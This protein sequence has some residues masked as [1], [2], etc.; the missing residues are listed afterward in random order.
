[1]SDDDATHGLVLAFDTDDPQFVRGV[2]IG[3]LWQRLE[4][5]PQGISATVRAE[6]AEMVIRIAEARG[7]PFSAEPAGDSG[8]WLWVT[9]G[10]PEPADA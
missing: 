6:S 4:Q 10:T 3:M 9:I 1:M 2:G 8:E 7:L 5:E